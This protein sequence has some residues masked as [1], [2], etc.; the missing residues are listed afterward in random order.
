MTL[1]Y[2]QKFD[3]LIYIISDTFS[4]NEATKKKVNYF[5]EPIQKIWPVDA[6]F[7]FAFSHNSHEFGK[8]Y[9]KCKSE[10]NLDFDRISQIYGE[11]NSFDIIVVDT[12]ECIMTKLSCAQISVSNVHYLGSKSGFELFQS[13]KHEPRNAEGTFI[14]I[15]GL[16][17][18]ASELS[19]NAYAA[20]LSAFKTALF[21]TDKTFGGIAVSYLISRQEKRYGTYADVYRAPIGEHE[22][23]PNTSQTISF[24]DESNGGFLVSVWGSEDCS[25]FYYSA[26]MI[27][28]LSNQNAEEFGDYR[29]CGNLDGYEFVN[30]TEKAGAGAGISSWDSWQS[31]G[32]KIGQILNQARV[33]PDNERVDFAQKLLI[34]M[35]D[36]IIK[37]INT[38]NEPRGITLSQLESIFSD[39]IEIN[40]D[41]DI[42]N[43]IDRYLSLRSNLAILT[44]GSANAV[45]LRQQHH[46]W[47]ESMTRLKFRIM[48]PPSQ[49][50]TSQTSDT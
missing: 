48:C 40:V 1:V 37:K 16:P 35:E 44:A 39:N 8:F 14:G 7:V 29:K 42:C 17:E 32:Q 45:P 33:N 3:D 30:I 23:L 36:S 22:L 31:M 9:K 43:S 12:K 41:V 10:T 6:R 49:S 2:A 15:V 13:L 27:G 20:S 4:E 18:G 19:C 25:A 28:Y 47:R 24:Q 26:A 34:K 11:S 21:N 50:L 46:V 38:I 5:T